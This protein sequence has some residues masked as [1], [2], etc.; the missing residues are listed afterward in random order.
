MADT[1]PDNIRHRKLLP[2]KNLANPSKFYSHFLYKALIVTV[3]VVVL[4]IFPSRAPEFINQTVFT[5]SWEL[6]HLIFVGIAVSYGLFSRRN[7]ETEKENSNSKFDN[8]HT[9]VSRWLEV[10]SD[11]DDEA[12]SPSGSD[13]SKVQTWSSQYRRNEPV[14]VLAQEH[15]VHAE[16]RST[17]EKPLLLPV[18]SLKSRVPDPGVVDSANESY[19]SG[20]SSGSISRSTSKPSSKGFSGNSNKTRNG[21]L[22]GLDPLELEARLM[23][24]VVHP[25]PVSWRSRSGR[26]E[27][28]EDVDSPTLYNLPPS[29]EESEFNRL[30]SR[31]SSSNQMPQSSRSSSNTSSKSSHSHSLSS[32]RK[33]SPSPSFSAESQAKNAEDL[34]RKKSFFK[35]PPAPPPPPPPPLIRRSSSVRP[36]ST[37]V[38][39]GVSLEKE[40]RRR[41]TSEPKKL[42][43]RVGE[44][45]V[46]RV[47]PGVEMKVRRIR[48]S[49]T[50]AGAGGVTDFGE[51]AMN[52]KLEK[53]LKEAQSTQVGKSGW[54]IMGFDQTSSQTKRLGGESVPVM[55]NP[56][57]MELSGEENQET[58]VS[59]E[60]TES[61]DDGIGGSPSN[62]VGLNHKEAASSNFSDGGGG[63]GPDVDKKADE[64]IAKF[65][66]QIRL[67]RIESIKRSSGQ[68]KRDSSR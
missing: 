45:Q 41:F 6:L 29:F 64:F 30:K 11:F 3:F 26:M 17:G 31:S 36:N 18:R 22:G 9:Y 57:F 10:S 43:K 8:A 44:S 66:E 20:Y 15:S 19:P 54:K 51:D 50:E 55:S 56:D 4:P 5:R 33:L 16:Q 48:A 58:M 63:G 42:N 59:D 60:D 32:A 65:R 37:F 40:L 53:G 28:E 47:N 49:E 23:D 62:G 38:S 46:G 21:G 12:E 25:S 68:I 35:S 34:V 67:Q 24:N 13:E 14:V 52:D 61:E 7:D 2:E 39:D 1:E 27:M